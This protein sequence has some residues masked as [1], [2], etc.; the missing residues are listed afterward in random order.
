VKHLLHTATR[1]VTDIAIKEGVTKVVIGDLSRIREN[2]NFGK[3]NNQKF[4]RFPY[5]KIEQLL[6]YKLAEQSIEVITVRAGHVLRFFK[7]VGTTS[8]ER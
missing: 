2:N 3:K 7:A 5:R 8:V 4:H 6:T 1:K